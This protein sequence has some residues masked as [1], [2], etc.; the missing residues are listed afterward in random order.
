MAINFPASPSTDETYT[1]NS[2]TWVFNGTSWNALGEQITPSDIGLGNVDNTADA[3]KPVST[4]QQIAIDA[5]GY[6]YSVKNYGATGDGTT[7]DTDAIQAAIDAA[8]ASEGTVFFP[9]GIY[10]YTASSQTGHGADKQSF[11]LHT[12]ITILGESRTGTIFKPLDAAPNDMPTFTAQVG[13]SDNITLCNFTIDG[14][15]SRAA[16]GG[17]SESEDE[18]INFKASNNSKVMDVTIH[19]MGQD[20]IDFDGGTNALV[21]GCYIY[22]CWGTGI[23]FAGSGVA[24]GIIS[25]CNLVNNAHGRIGSATPT[26]AYSASGVDA[27]GGSDILVTGCTFSINARGITVIGT[28][29]YNVSNCAIASG[30]T[31][32]GG[33]VSLRGADPSGAGIASF[34]NCIIVTTTSTGGTS[35]NIEDDF[36]TATFS[37]CHFQ[38]KD[39]IKVNEGG[40]L[41]V[42]GCNFVNTQ[43]AIHVLENSTKS[44]RVIGNVFNDT[45]FGNTLRIESDASGIFDGNTMLKTGATT[46]GI[47]LYAASGKWV[48]RNNYAPT[49]LRAVRLNSGTDGHIIEGNDFH[50]QLNVISSDNFIRNNHILDV[51]FNFAGT[52]GNRME[53]NN[54][55]GTITTGSSTMSSQTWKGNYGTGAYAESGTA[56]LVAGTVTVANTIVPA[57]ATIT[58]TRQITGG[59]AGHLTLSTVTAGTSFVI[60]SSDSA[61]TSTVFWKIE[62]Q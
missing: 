4:A 60:N 41:T 12:G 21:D 34:S 33:A 29:R 5:V 61:D 7:D 51:V 20:G 59:T 24:K 25:N 11:N 18:G 10:R 36:A 54:I 42:I 57:G 49:N 58:L 37:S 6:I 55:T 13:N 3:A 44:M 31:T 46:T 48:I 26:V 47:D 40:E 32:G 1:E 62:Y 22:D 28:S 52:T 30:N 2:I 56:V 8:I 15:K 9:T 45:L 39:G 35:V 17:G 27:I 16:V 14:N 43:H 38:G 23:H 50:G 53:D 19:D